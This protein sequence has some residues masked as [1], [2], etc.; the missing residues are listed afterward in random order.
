MAQ[1]IYDIPLKTI[2]GEAAKLGDSAGASRD[3]DTALLRYP[4]VAQEFVAY[5]IK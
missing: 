3:R 2:D 4:A 5:G 1:S